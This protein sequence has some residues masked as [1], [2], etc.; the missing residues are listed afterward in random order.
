MESRKVW[1]QMIQLIDKSIICFFKYRR[2]NI[3]IF[4]R[5]EY[6][7]FI[8]VFCE[9]IFYTKCYDFVRPVNKKSTTQDKRT[10]FNI[11]TKSYFLYFS[12]YI[13][14]FRFIFYP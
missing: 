10:I 14:W 9:Y 12:F 13:V 1:S 6:S 11:H 3:H 8:V 2:D 4:Y 5:E 7:V